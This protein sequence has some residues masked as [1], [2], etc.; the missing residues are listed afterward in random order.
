LSGFNNINTSTVSYCSGA[1]PVIISSASTPTS[2]IGATLNYSWEKRT[3]PGTWG[4]VIGGGI[5]FDPAISIGD[6]IHEFRRLITATASSVTCTPTESIYYSNTVT[7][8]IGGAAGSS[9]PI[10]LTSNNTPALSN[11]I[12]EGDDLIFTATSNASATFYEFFVNNVSQGLQASPTNTF[13]TSSASVTL[14]DNTV[15][16]VRV[17]TGATSRTGCFNDDIITLRVNSMSNPNI[18][19]YVGPNPICNG[20]NPPSINGASNPISD[21]ATDGGTI[22]YEWEQDIGDGRGFVGIASSD[23][24]NFDPPSP[25]Q[26]QALG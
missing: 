2:S 14:V 9:P 3:A 19:S 23:S 17:Y 26:D 20:D 16:R 15:V 6:G 24:P 13:D 18:I 4:A 21:L 25:K 1:D 10:S 22:V 8:T 12:C 7:I 11:I 5:N